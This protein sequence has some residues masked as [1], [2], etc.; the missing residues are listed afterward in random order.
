MEPP[1][2]LF[3]RPLQ[4]PEHGASIAAIVDRVGLP[5]ENQAATELCNA[6]QS[7]RVAA[8]GR[9]WV[10]TPDSAVCQAMPQAALDT[11]LV[12]RSGEPAELARALESL[13]PAG[14]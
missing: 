5:E 4:R 14:D 13:Y 3:D 1:E 7:Q 12:H 11:E 2:V 9:I 10:Q 8:G 6:A